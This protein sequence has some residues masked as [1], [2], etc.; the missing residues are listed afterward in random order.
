MLPVTNKWAV[1]LT[2]TIAAY[3]C[4]GPSSSS[5][6]KQPSADASGEPSATAP[7]GTPNHSD[8][9]AAASSGTHPSAPGT[10]THLEATSDL[11]TT[12]ISAADYAMYSAI[13]G[14]ASAMLS[15]L[16]PEDRAALE[17]ERRLT[18]GRAKMP[19]VE[20]EAMR[21]ARQLHEKDVELAR[22]QGVEPRYR[23]V[24]EKIEAVIG[25]NAK[26]PAPGDRVGQENLRYLEAHRQNI[27]R[28]QQIL[29][30]PL[31]RPAQ[32]QP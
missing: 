13:M 27:E 9:D 32:P 31:S 17:T 2:L 23:K 24:K 10:V 7:A 5:D 26:P 8:A 30:D 29:R 21:R 20:D 1:L 18:A 12:P 16:T 6:N 11:D 28:L 25:P 3:G 19:G 14:G 15:A 4:G 22:M